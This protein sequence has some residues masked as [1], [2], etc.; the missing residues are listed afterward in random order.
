MDNFKTIYNS[1][2]N[3]FPHKNMI[4]LKYYLLKFT[5]E[6]LNSFHP[7]IR[8]GKTHLLYRSKFYF[9]FNTI[10]L[11]QQPFLIS[12]K[13]NKIIKFLLSVL[14]QENQ[15]ISLCSKI[16]FILKWNMHLSLLCTWLF[17]HIKEVIK[18]NS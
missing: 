14:I 6:F 9:E 11:L 16:K 10:K 13:F 2:D 17:S 8:N 7:L 18:T 5:F 12:R 3:F 15:K 4:K 1:P